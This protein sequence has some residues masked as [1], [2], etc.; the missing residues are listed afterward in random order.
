[1]TVNKATVSKAWE[2]FAKYVGV[3]GLMGLILVF[4]FVYGSLQSIVLPDNYLSMM[5]LVIGY[6][7]AKNGVGIIAA[8]TG[9]KK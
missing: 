3:Q 4:G 5:T 8:L 2:D 1:M 7:F 6:Y 9:A